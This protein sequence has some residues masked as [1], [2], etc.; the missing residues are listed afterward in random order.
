MNKKKIYELFLAD[1]ALSLSSSLA[2]VF[3]LV[4]ISFFFFKLVTVS[5]S[6]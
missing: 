6:I 2:V 4:R 3:F 1:N 5:L